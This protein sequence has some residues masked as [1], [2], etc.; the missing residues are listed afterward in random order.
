MKNVIY[1]IFYYKKSTYL[2]KK[3]KLSKYPIY[4]IFSFDSHNKNSLNVANK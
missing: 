1:E 4:N 2:N 3:Q